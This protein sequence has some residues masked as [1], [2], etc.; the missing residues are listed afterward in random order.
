MMQTSLKN[1]T[2]KGKVLKMIGS[3]RIR[4]NLGCNENGK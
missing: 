4:N 2:K 3:S 1:Y